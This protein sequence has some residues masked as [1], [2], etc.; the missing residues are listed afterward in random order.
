M[1]KKSKLTKD[2]K[3]ILIS[4]KKKPTKKSIDNLTE[5]ELYIYNEHKLKYY[6]DLYNLKKYDYFSFNEPGSEKTKIKKFKNLKEWD[7]KEWKFQK[8]YNPDLFKEYNK[9]YMIGSW[10]RIYSKRLYF[11]KKKELIYGQLESAT[12]FITNEVTEKLNDYLNKTIPNEYYTPFN[13]TMFEK[14]NKDDK[15][16]TMSDSI[17]RA[18]GKEKEY[19]YFRK[20]INECYYDIE[21]EVLNELK[22]YEGCTF[23]KLSDKKIDLDFF[24]I[25]GITA[26]ENITFKNFMFKFHEYE[27]PFGIIENIIEKMYLF[28]KNYIFEKDDLVVIEEKSNTLDNFLI[29]ASKNIVDENIIIEDVK[30]AKSINSVFDNIKEQNSELTKL[31]ELS[32]LETELKSMENF[33]KKE[34]NTEIFLKNLEDIN[35]NLEQNYLKKLKFKEKYPQISKKIKSLQNLSIPKNT[36]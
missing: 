11:L 4:M 12:S 13:K 23:R 20:L 25:G 18:G 27:Q 22:N 29:N 26:A 8:K 5:E 35:K 19:L 24:L 21:K 16:Y 9:L 28:F 3:K 36:F 6:G 33:I 1:F 14:K 32:N 17:L 10:F 31:T 2:I 30:F 7:I 34:N 15:F